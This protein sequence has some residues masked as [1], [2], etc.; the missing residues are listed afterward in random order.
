MEHYLR[1]AGE[2]IRWKAARPALT[3]ELE[4]HLLDQR[5]ACLEAG[6]EETAA[7][8]EALRQMGDPVT[9]G[10]ELDRIHRPRPQRGLL[11]LTVVIAALGGVLR[12]LLTAGWAQGA[13]DPVKAALALAL[14]CLALLGGYGLDVSALGRHPGKV[15]LG[16]LCV[17]LLSLWLSP[18]RNHASYFTRYVV[19]AYPV[20]YAAWLYGCRNKGW[21]GIFLA[22]AGGFPLAAVMLMAPSVLALLLLAGTGLALW[23]LAAG[24]DWFSLGRRKTQGVVGG[25]GLAALAGVWAAAQTGIIQTR[26]ALLLHPERDPLGGGYQATVVRA[27]LSGA[28]WR[29]EGALGGA[30]GG[31]PYEQAMPEAGQDFLLTTLIHQWGWLAFWLVLAAVTGLLGWLLWRCLRQRN[32]LGR[33]VSLAVVL[34]LG[35]RVVCSLALTFGYVLL[36]CGMP[37]L[38]GN[39]STLL[40]MALIGLALSAFRREALSQSPVRPVSAA[41]RPLVSW[42]DGELVIALGRRPVAEE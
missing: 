22:L 12:V 8:A 6:M 5:D 25:L 40:D 2:Q 31:M 35:L 36:G 9:V 11:V 4:G 23:L 13:S 34:S 14:G 7:E 37:L 3:T 17:G 1:T 33:M 20:V 42:R 30:F 18:M 27:A 16:A 29:G 10:M 24:Q 19:L 15:Y 41:H 32:Q 39:L 26:L 28:R 21:R 38:S